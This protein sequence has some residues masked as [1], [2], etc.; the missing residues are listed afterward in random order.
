MIVSSSRVVVMEIPVDVPEGA[1]VGT[2]LGAAVKA[3]FMR[4]LMGPAGVRMELPM[5]GMVA[6]MP[7]VV[8]MGQGGGRQRRDGDGGRRYAWEE[9][10]GLRGSASPRRRGSWCIQHHS[11]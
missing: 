11:E 3:F 4:A 8:T 2:V 7:V 6:L 1:M 10:G 5:P 9:H